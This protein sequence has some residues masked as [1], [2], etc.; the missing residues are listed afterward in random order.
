MADEKEQA[1]ITHD[2]SRITAAN[3]AACALFRC[4]DDY[5][6]DRRI[7]NGITNDDFKGLAALRLKMMREGGELPPQKLPFM[8]HDN[9]KFWAEV[10]TRPIGDG[11]FETVLTYLYEY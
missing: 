2:T 9:T 4:D 6:I 10:K 11:L 5:L 1:I 7:A 8:R 3:Q